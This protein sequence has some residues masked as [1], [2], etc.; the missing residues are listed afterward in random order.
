MRVHL[1]LNNIKK[2]AIDMAAIR[3]TILPISLSRNTSSRSITA[4]GIS[5]VFLE[6]ILTPRK[7]NPT[8]KTAIITNT[9]GS[10]FTGIV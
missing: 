4:I 8:I 10:N 2:M 5:R 3:K 7:S 1:F 9:A 6:D